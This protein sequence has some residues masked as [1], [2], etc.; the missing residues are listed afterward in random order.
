MSAAPDPVPVFV[1]GV[2]R[3]GTTWVQ[4]IL[5]EHP[6]AWPLV[7]TYMFSRQVGL[8]ALLRSVGPDGDPDSMAV[9]PAG[10]GR[11]FSRAELVEELRAIARRWLRQGS[12]GAADFVV[13]KSPWHLRELEVIAEILPDARYVSVVR[14][15]RDVAVSLAAAR[16]TWSA[17]GSARF[18]DVVREAAELWAGGVDR[19]RTASVHLGERILEIRYED[20]HADPVEACSRLFRHAGMPHDDELVERAAR[21][22]AFDR[23]PDAKGEDRALRA[24]RV[25]DWRER[26]G[27]AAAWT[28]ERRAGRVLRETGYESDPRWWLRRPLRSRL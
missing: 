7:E 2:P 28:F 25:G 27:I 23:L 22:T 14:D 1:V 5:A 26:F 6:A 18:L 19:G 10:L 13:E 8:G 24:G 20:I 15:G 12:G 16:R 9:A 21:A 4:R 3:S 11:L 17:E